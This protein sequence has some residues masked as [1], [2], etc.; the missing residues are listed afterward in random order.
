MALCRLH[1]KLLLSNAVYTCLLSQLIHSFIHKHVSNKHVS[2]ML[3]HKA[4]PARERAGAGER[5]GQTRREERLT[6]ATEGAEL[7]WRRG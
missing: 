4:V 3:G 2:T 5:P 6:S 1:S 7:P